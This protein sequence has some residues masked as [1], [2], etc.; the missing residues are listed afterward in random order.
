ME[1]KISDLG[2]VGFGEHPRAQPTSKGARYESDPIPDRKGDLSK[3]SFGEEPKAQSTSRKT[4]Y[5]T[6]TRRKQKPIQVPLKFNRKSSWKAFQA[7]VDIAANINAWCEE[8]KAAFLASS[9]E[10]K[11]ALVLNNMSNDDRR[12]Y[13]LL[14]AALAV[15]LRGSERPT[16]PSW[17]ELS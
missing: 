17:L 10:G 5:D 11:A 16:S 4:S 3:V 6:C 2:K 7:Q 15:W 8:D 14:V 13:R 1:G 9:L 12:Y